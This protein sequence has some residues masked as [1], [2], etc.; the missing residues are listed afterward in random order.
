MSPSASSSQPSQISAPCPK[1]VSILQEPRLPSYQEVVGK[2]DCFRLPSYRESRQ[3]R[4]HPYTRPCRVKPADEDRTLFHTIYDDERIVLD[5]PPARG[6]RGYRPLIPPLVPTPL[7]AYV[8]HVR[9]ERQPRQPE[10]EEVLRRRRVTALILQEF[11]AGILAS[12]W[13]CSTGLIPLPFI[14]TPNPS[15]PQT[16]CSKLSYRIH[17]TL[18][19]TGIKLSYFVLSIQH[20]KTCAFFMPVHIPD[21]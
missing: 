12:L 14:L 3:P 10:D 8:D 19:Q 21:Y 5:V 13:C 4:Y 16:R 18:P 9:V 20:S 17:A 7:I 15:W 2:V 1:E 6:R 11:V